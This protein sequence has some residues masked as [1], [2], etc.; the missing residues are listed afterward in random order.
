M[1]EVVVA[2]QEYSYMTCICFIQYYLL[3]KTLPLLCLKRQMQMSLQCIFLFCFRN[4]HRLQKGRRMGR[5]TKFYRKGKVT[6]SLFNN[7]EMRR[8]CV[9]IWL[10][11][12]QID[13][14][15]KMGEISFYPHLSILFFPPFIFLLLYI[16][17]LNISFPFQFRPIC[18]GS[19][20]FPTQPW[21]KTEY[22]KTRLSVTQLNLDF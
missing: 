22:Y 1:K 20:P 2:W 13:S 11:K 7:Y 3:F 14:K 10:D 18:F 6:L 9:H 15:I 8:H 4:V 16:S 17:F 19:I 21:E 5:R 12:M